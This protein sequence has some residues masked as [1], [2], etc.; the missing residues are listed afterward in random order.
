LPCEKF[1][2]RFFQKATAHPT[3]GALVAVRTRRNLLIGVFFFA[4][5]RKSLATPAERSEAIFI[6]ASTAKE[7]SG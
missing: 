5:R 7:K 3:R 2:R 4:K 1:F 6:C